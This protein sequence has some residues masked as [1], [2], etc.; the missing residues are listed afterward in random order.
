MLADRGFDFVNQGGLSKGIKIN[1]VE[2]GK[3]V[4]NSNVNR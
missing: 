2:I 4:Y 3:R 1:D